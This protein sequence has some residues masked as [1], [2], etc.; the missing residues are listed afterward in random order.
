M[1]NY[2]RIVI[3][4]KCG[5]RFEHFTRRKGTKKVFCDD[6]LRKN[7]AAYSRRKKLCLSK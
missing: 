2:E 5:E 3:T 4:C 6:C 1:V 7:D